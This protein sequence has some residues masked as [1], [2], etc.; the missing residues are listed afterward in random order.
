LLDRSM[1]GRLLTLVAAALVCGLAGASLGMRPVMG[2]EISTN[3][4]LALLACGA[5]VIAARVLPRAPGVSRALAAGVLAFSSLMLAES[6]FGPRLWLLEAI[7]LERMPANAAIGLGLAAAALLMVRRAPAAAGLL[8]GLCGAI[9]ASALLGH[10]TQVAPAHSWATSLAM[11]PGT[12][13]CLVSLAIA[14]WPIANGEAEER[15]IVAWRGPL[16]AGVAVASLTLLFAQA[17]R[18]R[19]DQSLARIVESG[20]ERAET[21]I[22]SGIRYRTLALAMLSD[23]WEERLLRSRRSWETDARLTLSQS[24]GLLATEWV[25]AD[26]YVR[27]TYPEEIRLPPPDVELLPRKSSQVV[28]AAPFDLAPTGT[29]FRALAPIRNAEAGGQLEGWVSGAFVASKLFADLLSDLSSSYRV[30]VYA[31][32]RLL[33]R[34]GS[35]STAE[36]RRFAQTRRVQLPGT[37]ALEVRVEPSEVLAASAQSRLSSVLI[38]SGL[39]VSV[40]LTLA[41]GLGRVATEKARAHARAAREVRRLN[42]DLE[43]RVVQRT[44]ELARSNEG[45]RQFARFLSHELRQPLSSQVIWADLLE[46]KHGH[47]L[48]DEG[49]DWLAQLRAGATR[50]GELLEAQLSL[51]A[52]RSGSQR[53]DRVDLGVLMHRVCADLADPIAGGGG[54]VEISRLPMVLG[55]REQIEQLFRNLIEN[56]VKYRRPDQPLHVRVSGSLARGDAIVR[57]EDNGIGFPRAEAAHIFEPSVR[58]RPGAGPG[59]GMGLA[60]CKRIALSH[61][62]HI[63]ASAAPGGGSVFSVRLPEVGQCA[64]RE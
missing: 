60:L 59:D 12:S 44:R 62:G 6:I 13:L 28:L 22:R 15:A 2:A 11:T 24:R 40:L 19:D 34:R 54:S 33:Y 23:E 45:L 3:A 32:G 36:Q 26:G 9:G 48:D 58:L 5:G 30:G 64:Q 7:G 41:L 16:I 29:A 27:W 61:G 52:G 37:L 63:S 46:T 50:M 39:S 43:E 57:V 51:V 49:R 53:T 56:A 25:R 35:T 10:L 31:N 38:A 42:A 17:L 47:E 18:L 8:G 4:A 21:R 14:L 1:F 20:A 55:D